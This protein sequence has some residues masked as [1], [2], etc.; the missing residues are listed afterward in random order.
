[1]ASYGDLVE[2]YS[3]AYELSNS[4]RRFLV[5]WGIS[6]C[7]GFPKVLFPIRD[8]K[9]TTPARGLFASATIAVVC[10]PRSRETTTLIIDLPLAIVK[11]GLLKFHLMQPPIW[12][13][14]RLA[15][16]GWRSLDAFI[17]LNAAPL[18][19]IYNAR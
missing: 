11:Q 1:M 14:D 9:Q 15:K 12:I 10:A 3:R 2:L 17:N 13:I 19:L 8:R 7:M 6:H 16:I 18:P 4:P 5:A